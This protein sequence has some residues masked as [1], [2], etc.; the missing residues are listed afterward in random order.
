VSGR[1]TLVVALHVHAGREAEFER[2]E[3]AA[4]AVMQRHG[5]AIERRIAID[6]GG[7]PPHP[8]EVHVVTFPDRA[9]FDRY[10]ADPAL[11]PLAALRES[12]IRE[13]VMWHGIEQTPFIARPS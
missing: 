4:S 11:E 6:A 10:R 1:L 2:F 8:H 3:A 13:T 5:G 9:A 12:A 7:H